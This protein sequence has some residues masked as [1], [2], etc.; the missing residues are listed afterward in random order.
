MS[1]E[2]RKVTLVSADLPDTTVINLQW[3]VDGSAVAF[4]RLSNGGPRKIVAARVEDGDE[5]ILLELENGRQFGMFA[6]N[7]VRRELL[8]PTEPTTSP[9]LPALPKGELRRYSTDTGQYTVVD[10]PHELIDRVAWSPDG[11]LLAMAANIPGAIRTRLYVLDV[12]SGS[13]TAVDLRRGGPFSMTWAGPYLF[14]SYE[15]S[16]PD[17]R[18]YLMR[19]DSRSKD[20]QQVDRPGLDDVLGRFGAISAPRCTG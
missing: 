9:R 20:R 18:L 16:T 13:S 15:V 19:W 1:L 17:D 10:T 7:S 2:S 14:Y 6:W 5:R 12:S 8:V 11:R 3:S 4:T